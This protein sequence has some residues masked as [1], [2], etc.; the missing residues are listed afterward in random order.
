MSFM[1]GVLFVY[2]TFIGVH[3]FNK[4]NKMSLSVVQ[5]KGRSFE[6]R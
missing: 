3:G 2:K 6:L 5:K 1:C 4:N